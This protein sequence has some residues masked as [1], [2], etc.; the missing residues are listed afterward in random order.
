MGTRST[1]KFIRKRGDK[2]EP[3]V[4][5]YQQYDGYIEGVGH[6][7]AEFI[8]S[9]KIINGIGYGQDTEE[10][11]NGFECLIAQFIRDFKTR[12]GGLYITP[13]DDVEEY[14]YEVVCNDNNDITI[15]VTN[16]DNALIFSGTPTELLAYK[17]NLD[18]EE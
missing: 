3:L 10:Y 2:L 12:V 9:K 1:T 18:E 6:E 11:A 4:N 15:K 14:N 8:L 13:M 5:I 16:W 7:I 17:E